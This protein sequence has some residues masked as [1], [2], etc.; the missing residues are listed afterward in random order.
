MKNI[1]LLLSLILIACTS[2]SVIKKDVVT[3]YPIKVQKVI[4]HKRGLAVI[5]EY[6]KLSDYTKIKDE[7]DSL[8]TRTIT[9]SDGTTMVVFCPVP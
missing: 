2:T 7:F 8:A 4:K 3:E 6:S 5:V 1:I 9:L